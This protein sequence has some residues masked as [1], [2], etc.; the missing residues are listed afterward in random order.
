ML[1]VATIVILSILALL[2]VGTGS[3]YAAYR[4]DLDASRRRSSEG[5]RIV[6]TASGPIEVAEAGHGTPVLIVHGAGGGFDQGLELGMPLV[7]RGVR[8]IAM[9][10]FGYLRTPLPTDASAVAQADAHAALLDALGMRRAAVLG[11]SAGAPSAMQFA[12]RYPERCAALV[13]FA[14]ITYKP[15]DVAAA[16]PKMSARAEKLLMTLVGSDAVF[17]LAL[18]F[19]QAE[20]VRRVLGTPPEI[21]KR[22]SKDERARVHR[23][24]QTIT[25]I[26]ARIRGIVNDQHICNSLPRYQLENIHAPTLIIS[27]RD[28]GY[29]TF[30]GAAYTAD[31]IP[32]SRFIGYDHGGHLAVGHQTEVVERTVRFLATA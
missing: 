7:G 9:S 19:A 28:D 24:L 12:I 32:A 11:A 20:I 22:T 13:L 2:A 26:G 1:G 30:A 8:I 31:Q 17:W 27:A 10:R 23:I 5:S 15:P 21:V 18:R 3:V 25:P 29:G 16:A 4:R 6:A 14:P